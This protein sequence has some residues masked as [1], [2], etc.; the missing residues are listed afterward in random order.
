MRN[1]AFSCIAGRK[2]PFGNSLKCLN[3]PMLV[4]ADARKRRNGVLAQL[5]ERQ[6][7][8]LKVRSSIL[9]C[10]TKSISQPQSRPEDR[11]FPW[12]EPFYGICRQAAD[13]RSPSFPDWQNPIFLRTTVFVFVSSRHSWRSVS[14]SS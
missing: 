13:S 5:V 1:H 7:R 6:V 12:T 8:N 2:I 4:S 3:L 11:L 10:S 9:L 14:R